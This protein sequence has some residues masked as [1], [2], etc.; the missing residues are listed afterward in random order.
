MRQRHAVAGLFL[1]LTAVVG[2]AG[3]GG[4]EDSAPPTAPSASSVPAG[5]SEGTGA[6]SGEA[7]KVPGGKKVSGAAPSSLD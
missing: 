6:A 5:T 1:G 3:C 4:G 7:T 2:V